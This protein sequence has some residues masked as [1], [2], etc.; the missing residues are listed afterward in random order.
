MQNAVCPICGEAV[1]F[2]PDGWAVEVIHGADGKH[3]TYTERPRSP[4]DPP[5]ATV[6]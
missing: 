1:A 3:V 5:P 4:E 2:V 6:Q